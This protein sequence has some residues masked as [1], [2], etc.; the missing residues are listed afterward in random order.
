MKN[1]L[2]FIGIDIGGT[3]VHL[4]LIKD[5]KILQQSKFSTIEAGH[6][7]EVLKTM[8]AHIKT[9]GQSGLAGIGLGIPGLVDRK[10]GVVYDVINISGW[11]ELA[12][13]KILEE[14][15]GVPVALTNDA[16]TF[17]L[18]E[19]KYGAGQTSQHVAA[20]SLGTGIGLGII[21]KKQLHNGVLSGAGEIGSLPYLSETFE[22]YCS[23]KYFICK[24]NS[25][26]EKLAID[27]VAGKEEALVIFQDYG[28]HLGLLIHTILLI[29]SPEIIVLG[30]SISKASPYFMG[31]L[32]KQ[33][34]MFP[35]KGILQELKIVV[36]TLHDAQVLGA[37][38]LIEEETIA[39]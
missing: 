26:A 16:N 23:G 3:K 1:D 34:E 24:H 14:Q 36:S 27:A 32:Q 31:A 28:K 22:D 20:I 35:F 4:A 18:G 25:T 9:L 37:A 13:K 5:G 33:L 8:I 17:A 7:D 29:L 2:P 12:L 11:K 21:I 39:S 38:A 15:F 30:G 19:L 6:G 10:N